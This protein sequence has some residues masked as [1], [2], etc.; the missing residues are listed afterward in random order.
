MYTLNDMFTYATFSDAI[1]AVREARAHGD[2]GVMI[3]RDLN[4]DV[5]FFRAAC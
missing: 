1:E 5:C 3:V 2:N 4:G